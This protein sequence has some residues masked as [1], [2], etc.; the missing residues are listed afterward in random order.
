MSLKELSGS[1]AKSLISEGTAGWYSCAANPPIPHDKQMVVSVQGKHYLVETAQLSVEYAGVTVVGQNLKA[2]HR[3]QASGEIAELLQAEMET[4]QAC[5]SVLGI[6]TY[7]GG[8]E[9]GP[10]DS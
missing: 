9:E 7:Y 4:L 5:R 6:P 8:N 2:A 3:V 1:E 10:N